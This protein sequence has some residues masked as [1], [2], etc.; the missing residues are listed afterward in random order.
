VALLIFQVILSFF[1]AARR[2]RKT[3]KDARRLARY[4]VNRIDECLD[5][6]SRRIKENRNSQIQRIQ[7]GIDR[8]NTIRNSFAAE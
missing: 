1:L 3:E 4:A 8:L 6:A 5:V 7:Q 2:I